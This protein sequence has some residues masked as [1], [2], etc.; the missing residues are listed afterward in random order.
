[1]SLLATKV[2]VMVMLLAL[3]RFS[4][5][6]V[7]AVLFFNFF[8]YP[9]LVRYLE[10]GVL[11]KV[12]TISPTAEREGLLPP[13]I[14]FCPL[15]PAR[16]YAMGWKNSTGVELKHVIDDN[17]ENLIDHTDILKCIQEKAY[18][19]NET[20]L[21]AFDGMKDPKPLLNSTYWTSYMTVTLFGNCYTLKY[22]QYFSAD[23]EL[24]SIFLTFIQTLYM[25]FTFTTQ[26]TFL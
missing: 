14:T 21:D 4:F 1:L 15:T 25:M 26:I 18:Q 16:P 17:C 3:A 19:L 10:K 2:S 7:L 8:G 22:P 23:F 9:A 5:V 6:V 20:L 13:A 24:H 11:I 12:S